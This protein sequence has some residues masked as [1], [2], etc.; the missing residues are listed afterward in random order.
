M[1]KQLYIKKGKKYVPIGY[2]DGFI[3]FPCEGLWAV[4]KKDKNEFQSCI[5]QV[6]HFKNIDYNLLAS[7]I[8]KKED[9]CVNAIIKASKEHISLQ[10]IVRIIFEELCKKE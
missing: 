4:Y 8:K 7:L 2:S 5:A 3:G 10:D 1:N 6:G 9:D